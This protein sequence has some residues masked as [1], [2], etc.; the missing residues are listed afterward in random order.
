M[1]AGRVSSQAMIKIKNYIN[2]ALAEPVGGAYFDNINPATSEV[3]SLIPDS[4]GQDVELA[5]Q[6]A[7]KAFAG[8]STM[9]AA[10]RS[11][12]LLRLSEA[13]EKNLER[14]AM[15]ETVDSG[16]PLWLSKSVD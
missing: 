14:L 8:W 13:I 12:I 11:G 7:Q 3:Y 16:K 6:A 1:T 10:K 15:A 9:A 4:D 2:G 5:V